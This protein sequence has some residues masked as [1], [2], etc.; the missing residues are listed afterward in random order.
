MCCDIPVHRQSDAEFV[1]DERFRGSL[2]HPIR[3]EMNSTLS[4]S[5]TSAMS[6]PVDTTTT[7]PT[8]TR[9]GPPP[10][11]TCCPRSRPRAGLECAEGHRA[12]SPLQTA[13]RP[14]TAPPGEARRD[15]RRTEKRNGRLW[16]VVSQLGV[17]LRASANARS[18]KSRST[19]SQLRRTAA[20]T[21]SA[22][23]WGVI[24]FISGA[25]MTLPCSATTNA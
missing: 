22:R 21:A 6:A 13:F 18:R 19:S 12:G 23:S 9:S 11:A 5:V 17:E 24:L 10:Q 8:Q 1:D 14:A 25:V 7:E 15:V 2:G 4:S 20:S 3:S 16:S